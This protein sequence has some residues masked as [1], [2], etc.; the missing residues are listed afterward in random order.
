MNKEIKI[1]I[2]NNLQPIE[3]SLNTEITPKNLKNT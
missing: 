2:Q 1:I 3:I